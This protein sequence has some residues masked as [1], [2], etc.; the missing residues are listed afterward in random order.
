MK[1]ALILLLFGLVYASSALAGEVLS[2][3][4]CLR[5]ALENYPRLKR[6]AARTQAREALKKAAEKDL[7]PRLSFGYRYSRLRDRQKI[8]I[9]GHDVP[10]SS[11]EMVEADLTLEVPVFY[12]FSLRIKKA[13]AALEAD[14]ARVEEER[15][16]Q[17]IAFEVKKAYYSYLTA[18]RRVKEAQKSLMRLKEHLKMARAFY[19]KGLVARHQVLASEVAVAEAEHRLVLA[20]NT[21]KIAGYRLN[22]LLNRKLTAPLSLRDTLALSPH[23]K[24]LDVYLEE[25][26][27]RRPEMQAARLA[28]EMARKKIQLAKARYYPQ[29][30]LVGLYQ[31]RGTDLLASQ[32]PYWD[33][34]N[35]V[36]TLNLRL[37]LWDW[38][39][40]GDQVAAARAEA[41][42]QQEAVRELKK[43]IELEVRQAYLDFSAAKKRL[44]LAQKALQSA[45]ENFRLEK[46]RFKEGLA[47]TADV[48]DAEAFLAA[49]E[50]HH[51]EALAALKLAHAALLLAVGAPPLP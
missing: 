32:D 12:G 4:D 1:R 34:E 2:L 19:A 11:Y 20:Q 48:L 13:L 15:G 28:L 41:L 33:R 40:R 51:L 14:V 9:L 37:L 39:Q 43:E 17:Q 44:K 46:A 36:F 21:L 5:L 35:I 3:T 6:L 47:P 16:R 23:I 7:L 8:V 49:A 29:V 27:S 30:D 45:Q 25:A 42:A 18:K 50:A 10:I 31:K 26:L 24:A 38:G 22:F